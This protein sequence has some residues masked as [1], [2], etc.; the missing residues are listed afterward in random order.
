MSNYIKATN[1][2]IKDTLVT[3]DPNKRIKGSEIDAEFVSIATAISSKADTASPSFTGTPTAPTAPAGNNST[4]IATTSFVFQNGVPV[5][6]IFM[7]GG[8]IADIPAGY[9]LCDGTGGTPDLRNRFILGS[10][11]T[12]TTGATGGS[13]D[14]VVV[15]HTHT[16]TDPGHIHNDSDGSISSGSGAGGGAGGVYYGPFNTATNSNTTGIT[17]NTTGESGT[18]KNLPPYY[19]LAFIQRVS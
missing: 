5:G 13:K 9:A 3:G 1:F 11:S 14:A 4:Q 7:W 6:A 16:L 2:T 18:D 10:G 15:S 19:A 12:Y 8:L 17:I